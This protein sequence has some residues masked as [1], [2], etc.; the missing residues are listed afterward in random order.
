MFP[1]ERPCTWQWDS[2]ISY[3]LHSLALILQFVSALLAFF[4]SRMFYEVVWKKEQLA[5]WIFSPLTTL[6]QQ[7]VRH[8]WWRRVVIYVARRNSP[9][10]D[11]REWHRNNQVH[12][13]ACKGTFKWQAEVHLDNQFYLSLCVFSVGQMIKQKVLKCGIKDTCLARQSKACVC[14]KLLTYTNNPSQSPLMT[15]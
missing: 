14:V 4:V 12:L 5:F 3:L 2:N 7:Q 6:S 11:G 1:T 8:M 15:H 9:N 13:Q 10:Q